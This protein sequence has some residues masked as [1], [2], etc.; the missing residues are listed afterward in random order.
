M[1]RKEYPQLGETVWHEI[2]PN[3]LPVY[4]LT[5][6]ESSGQFA[7][8]AVRCGGASTCIPDDRGGWEELPAG[9]A[10]YL[11]HKMFDTEEGSAS[12]RF[13]ESGASDNAFTSETMTAYYFTGTRDFEQNLR[14]LLEMVSVPWFTQE[15]VDKERGII[16][17][18]I[19]MNEDDPYD[20]SYRRLMEMMY[21]ADPVKTRVVGTEE[22]IQHI[23]P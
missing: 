8:F 17:Q 7:C 6:P 10:H 4:V 22:S 19:R 14:I 9:M 1:E 20:E 18:E 5:R 2:L 23:T 3:G 11:E 12:D 13:G 15:S 21:A 16:A